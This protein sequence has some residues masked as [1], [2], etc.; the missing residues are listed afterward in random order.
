MEDIAFFDLATPK[1][2]VIDWVY[3]AEK[4]G[5]GVPLL[6]GRQEIPAE[7]ASGAGAEGGVKIIDSEEQFEEFL[8][9]SG[10]IFLLEPT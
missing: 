7:E 10:E 1:Y 6:R 4:G 3:R 2:D 8:A 9:R 5:D